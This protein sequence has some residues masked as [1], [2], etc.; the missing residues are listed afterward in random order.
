[1]SVRGRGSSRGLAPPR[2]IE[3][4]D[5]L[6][7]GNKKV[8]N[9]GPPSIQT[10]SKPPIRGRG[11]IITPPLGGRGGPSIVRGAIRGGR[12]LGG[13]GLA[14]RGGRGLGGFGLATRGGLPPNPSTN[15][16][17][18]PRYGEADSYRPRYSARLPP[19]PGSPRHPR[20][21]SEYEEWAEYRLRQKEWE[22]DREEEQWN[23]SS[24]T[25]NSDNARS[26]S[27]PSSY[28]SQPSTSRD[29]I[30]RYSPPQPTL[31]DSWSPHQ[32]TRP[33]PTRNDSQDRFHSSDQA[34]PSR[35]PADPIIVDL[36][37]F[38]PTPPQRN[39]HI[40]Q[41]PDPANH[42][43]RQHHIFNS[44]PSLPSTTPLQ[45]KLD[46]AFKR[47]PPTGP[48]SSRP[49]S[50]INVSSASN[51]SAKPPVNHIHPISSITQS[52]IST[53]DKGKGKAIVTPQI[54]QPQTIEPPVEVKKMIFK[55]NNPNNPKPKE[56]EKGGSKEKQ[57]EVQIAVKAEPD[58]EP[59]P[60]P[61]PSIQQTTKE[62]NMLNEEIDVKPTIK[63]LE[64]EIEHIEGGIRRSGTVAFTKH[65]LPECWSKNPAEKSQARMA[66]RK[67]QR[68]DMIKQGK[69]IGGTH[70]RD[71]GVAFDWTLPDPVPAPKPLPQTKTVENV[72]Q[73]DPQS[74][75]LTKKVEAV[76]TQ[77][78]PTPPPISIPTKSIPVPVAAATAAAD[79]PAIAAEELMMNDAGSDT[80]KITDNLSSS[81]SD[82]KTI[83]RGVSYPSKF[84]SIQLRQENQEDF[85]TWKDGIITKYTEL[86]ST[87]SRIPTCTAHHKKEEPKMLL[88]IHPISAENQK[89]ANQRI[90]NSRLEDQNSNKKKK[91]LEIDPSQWKNKIF[92]YYEVFKY[93]IGLL[94][95][96][97]QKDK[98]E[99]ASGQTEE[100]ISK[101]SN[102][103]SKPDERGRPTR[104]TKIHKSI[105]DEEPILIVLSKDKC[106][107]EIESHNGEKPINLDINLISSLKRKEQVNESGTNPVKYLTHLVA[108]K[109]KDKLAEIISSNDVNSTSPTTRRPSNIVTSTSQ[110]SS[111]EALSNKKK[112]SKRAR[113]AESQ[114][115]TTAVAPQHDSI[116]ELKTSPSKA[117]KPSKKSK[118]RHHPSEDNA[119]GAN[120]IPVSS[121]QSIPSSTTTT[122]A[123]AT[124][125]TANTVTI[126]QQPPRTTLS[127]AV[128]STF[129]DNSTP[130]EPLITVNPT[131]N[132]TQE[133]HDEPSTTST[134]ISTIPPNITDT[135]PLI[136]SEKLENLNK[137]LRE[138]VTEI[139]KWTK[140]S[141]EFPD[142]KLAL[143]VQIGKTREEIF[144]LY[145]NI[146]L[147]K[148]NLRI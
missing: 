93:P 76:I 101:I 68:D 114:S 72:T 100:W 35:R 111:D 84:S 71:D 51:T 39:S 89:I 106:K 82:N 29:P 80:T 140:L 81:S 50:P 138:K 73:V 47:Q 6:G 141:T 92:R 107:Q 16:N 147:E 105:I 13:F 34:G 103:V 53:V 57:Q 27:G 108:R 30:K 142:L 99:F 17:S 139:E 120:T 60:E 28:Q 96:E 77:R 54:L 4:R 38:P 5:V 20:L 55:P 69:K 52:N 18:I 122:K 126:P 74:I 31:Q 113:E 130:V 104:W 118:K 146:A 14:T 24:N 64:H 98:T 88:S 144:G 49:A 12:G 125:S 83:Y 124:S 91:K 131:F 40:S 75:P 86:Y 9:L 1:M 112:S 59:E 70:W 58:A 134:S 25:I 87:E 97:K 8:A 67:Q 15:S 110:T 21:K 136:T 33:I 128:P 133:D 45:S 36:T 102:I 56:K 90:D 41:L 37:E 26:S 7:F 94:E 121:S 46:P 63:E 119:T 22:R 43:S 48:S 44:S 148:T 2:I 23:N 117:D 65:E 61:E 116:A 42:S 137:L 79:R 66:F 95:L 85:R 3:D 145:D 129:S 19:P 127:T 135:K 143:N 62:E 115:A 10:F 32:T 132:N 109:N 78:N 123:T 11:G